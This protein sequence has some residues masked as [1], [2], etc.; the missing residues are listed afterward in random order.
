M[1][2]SQSGFRVIGV[3]N[4]LKPLRHYPFPYLCADALETLS[5]LHD[6]RRLEWSDGQSY[7]LE[8]FNAIHASP[9]CQWASRATAWRGDRQRHHNLIPATR[10]ALNSLGAIPYII[11]NVREARLHLESPFMLCGTMFGENYQSHRYF[12]VAHSPV[13][14]FSPATCQHSSNNV[15][16]DHGGKYPESALRDALEVQWMT[17]RETRQ[18]IS[19]T[20]TKFIGQQLLAFLGVTK[21]L[22]EKAKVVGTV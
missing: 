8:D 12:E 5:A 6:G 7:G 19:P 2:Y 21:P 3:D 15:S 22:V 1:G 10:A 11:E 13:V 17:V 4:D 16:R 14:F 9:P 18:A 20:Y